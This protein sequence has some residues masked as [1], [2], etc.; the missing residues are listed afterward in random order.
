MKHLLL[1]TIARRAWKVLEK[2]VL[3]DKM[4]TLTLFAQAVSNSDELQEKIRKGTDLI[5]LSKKT[6]MT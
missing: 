1:T 3:K 2:H 5:L 4:K 6:V